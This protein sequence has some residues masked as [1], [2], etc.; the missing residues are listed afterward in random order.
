APE[1]RVPQPAGDVRHAAGPGR[2]RHG[3]P[4]RRPRGRRAERHPELCRRAL[5]ARR[6]RD[7][8]HAGRAAPAAP[9]PGAGRGRPRLPRPAPAVGPPGAARSPDR[10][11][12]GPVLYTALI[13]LAEGY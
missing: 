6:R 4:P 11:A 8:P 2:G 5:G 1:P 10:E 13:V 3:G 9:R 7:L 12:E